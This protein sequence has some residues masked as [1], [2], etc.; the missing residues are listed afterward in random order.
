MIMTTLSAKEISRLSSVPYLSTLFFS[1][2]ICFSSLLSS[3][4]FFI[5]FLLF[6]VSAG[7]VKSSPIPPLLN[8]LRKSALKDLPLSVLVCQVRES[9]YVLVCIYMHVCV[10]LRMLG[11]VFV[12]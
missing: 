10:M 4:L 2:L 11:C 12:T 1:L 7:T 5:S 3:L 8:V 6:S 9:A